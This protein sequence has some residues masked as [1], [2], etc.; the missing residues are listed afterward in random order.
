MLMRLL[1]QRQ[2][3]IEVHIEFWGFRN[4]TLGGFAAMAEAGTSRAHTDW[5]ILP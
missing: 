1:L 5:I 3:Q 2:E 4:C